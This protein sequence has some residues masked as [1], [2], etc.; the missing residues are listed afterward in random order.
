MLKVILC[1]LFNLFI[2]LQFW[3]SL[4]GVIL[5]L[6]VTSLALLASSIVVI[7]FAIFSLISYNTELI[8]GILLSG[9]FAGF[10]VLIISGL[11]MKLFEWVAKLF[12]RFTKMYIKF[13][14]RFIKK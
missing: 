1:I 9:L 13:N 14:M 4:F 6:F 5:G 10:G 7:V 2:F 11:L 12:F 3:F 8:K